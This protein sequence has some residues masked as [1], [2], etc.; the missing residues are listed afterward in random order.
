MRVKNP[1]LHIGNT[2]RLIQHTVHSTGV[3]AY[4]MIMT[5]A[6]HPIL[7]TIYFWVSREDTLVPPVEIYYRTRYQDM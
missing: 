4:K 3:P 7:E 5:K 1:L 6:V 2:S